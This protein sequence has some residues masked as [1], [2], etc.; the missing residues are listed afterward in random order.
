MTNYTTATDKALEA[1]KQAREKLQQ[2]V[3]ALQAFKDEKFAALSGKAANYKKQL[4]ELEVQIDAKTSE[5][6]EAI[7]AKDDQKV[8]RL[9]EEIRQLTGKAE[10][11]RKIVHKTS[12]SEAKY[13][14][15]EE[16]E[17]LLR[18]VL[19]A[20]AEIEKAQAAA[21]DQLDAI[22]ANAEKEIAALKKQ[23]EGIKSRRTFAAEMKYLGA[24]DPYTADG[25]MIAAIVQFYEDCFGKM[26]VSGHTCG[27]DISA[28]VRYIRGGGAD[29]GL[30]HTPI[31]GTVPPHLAGGGGK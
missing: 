23:I 18:A 27:N 16:G 12:T 14:Q 19:E 17:A 31:A 28:K 15:T 3:K 24:Y 30:Q 22:C 13:M 7:V 11:L 10:P 4:E 25:R 29:R 26:D 20:W 21:S 8:T 6:A 2:A 1:P 9:E 5:L